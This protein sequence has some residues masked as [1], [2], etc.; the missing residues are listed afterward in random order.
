MRRVFYSPTYAALSVKPHLHYKPLINVPEVNTLTGG[1]N[2]QFCMR[3]QIDRKTIQ[4]YV[5]PW[6]C[7]AIRLGGF[8]WTI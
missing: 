8:G 4:E 7:S 5:K 2:R 3:H 1:L 6:R